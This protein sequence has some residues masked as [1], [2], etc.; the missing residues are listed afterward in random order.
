MSF[1]CSWET[2]RR[3]IL[4]G[5]L[6]KVLFSYGRETWQLCPIEIKTTLDQANFQKTVISSILLRATF[7]KQKRECSVKSSSG[8]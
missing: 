7:T 4:A 8:S 3:A 1:L 2:G 5:I 6:V